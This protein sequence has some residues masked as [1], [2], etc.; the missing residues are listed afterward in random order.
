MFGADFLC[1]GA[2]GVKLFE[3]SVLFEKKSV[4]LRAMFN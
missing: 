2:L 1:F 4:S 3:E